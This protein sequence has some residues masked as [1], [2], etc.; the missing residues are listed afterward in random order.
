MLTQQ[1]YRFHVCARA[2]RS[3]DVEVLLMVGG[4]MN[5]WAFDTVPQKGLNGRIGYQPL[6]A[7]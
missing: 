3:D 7:I 6:P 2:K 4:K 5:N 1:P